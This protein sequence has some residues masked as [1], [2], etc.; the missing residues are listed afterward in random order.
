MDR[1]F[2]RQ[3]S[4]CAAS[5]AYST[6]C[7]FITGNAPGSPRHT[8]HTLVFG[9]LPNCVEQPQKIFVCVSSWTWTSSPITASY[10]AR[11]AAGSSVDVTMGCDY[12]G[13]HAA[14]DAVPQ[15][16]HV[17]ASGGKVPDGD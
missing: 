3:L 6:A 2:T 5:T 17:L 1:A 10:L 7:R 13:S 4:A 16:L 9:G 11:T 14:L 15:R 12:S 8:G